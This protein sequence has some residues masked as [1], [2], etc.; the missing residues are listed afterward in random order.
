M[1][2]RWSRI[3]PHPCCCVPTGMQNSG[4]RTQSDIGDC[5]DL[6]TRTTRPAPPRCQDTSWRSFPYPRRKPQNPHYHQRASI[7]CIR[8]DHG[9]HPVLTTAASPHLRQR[10]RQL[11]TARSAH[12]GPVLPPQCWLAVL[13]NVSSFSASSAKLT[14]TLMVLPSSSRPPRCSLT[15]WRP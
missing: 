6:V 4:F 5:P 11:Q 7:S 14:F 12:V 10:D 15:P 2:H 9:P 13:V 8:S 1:S 3:C